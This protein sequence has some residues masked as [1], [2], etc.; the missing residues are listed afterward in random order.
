MI[1]MVFNFR[2]NLEK[3]IKKGV[4]ATI[5]RPMFNGIY[6][7]RFLDRTSK[8][9]F[10][11]TNVSMNIGIFLG[12]TFVMF[13]FVLPRLGFEKTIIFMGVIVISMVKAFFDQ[14]KA[15]EE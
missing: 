14:Q 7:K 11:I 12:T 5:G 10:T 6:N 3:N 1:N 8:V 13:R 15:K 2:K 4:Y 9:I